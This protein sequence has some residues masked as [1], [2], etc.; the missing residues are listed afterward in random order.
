MKRLSDLSEQIQAWARSFFRA[1]ASEKA[2]AQPRAGGG[3]FR[4]FLRAE[5]EGASLI[6][7]AL[8]LPIVMLVM[9]GI[10]SIGFAYYNQQALEEG[11]SAG[12]QYLSVSRTTTTNPCADVYAKLTAA[13]PHLLGSNITL[14][15]WMNGQEEDGNSCAGTQ[16]DYLLLGSTVSVDAKY[17]CNIG[18]FGANFDPACKLDG[19][20][21]EYVY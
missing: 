19:Y 21:S 20:V 5:D 15:I 10:F 9:T 7:V 14:K 6:E 13:A 11:V 17:P 18:V 8:C 2:T 1:A 12:A 3:R 16:T 4:A